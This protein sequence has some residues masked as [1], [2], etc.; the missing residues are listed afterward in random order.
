MSF[1]RSKSNITTTTTQPSTSC[2]SP[3]Y[4]TPASAIFKCRTDVN[5]FPYPRFYRGQALYPQP[6]VWDREAGIS[7]ILKP[8]PL[9]YS[10]PQQDASSMYC[11]EA[12]CNTTFPCTSNKKYS[13]PDRP[14]EISP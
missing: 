4:L 10:S 2:Y 3:V 8:S 1:A 13:L 14:V 9:V 11:F 6:I 5:E 12:P 7:P